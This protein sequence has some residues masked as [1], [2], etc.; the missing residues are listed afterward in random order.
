MKVLLIQQPEGLITAI[1]AI[2]SFNLVIFL[3]VLLMVLQALV[4][5]LRY[6]C[7]YSP[8]LSRFHQIEATCQYHRIYSNTGYFR[9][10][11]LLPALSG[12]QML[13]RKRS[14]F[15]FKSKV[16]YLLIWNFCL[17]SKFAVE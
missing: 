9:K 16:E 12:S 3:L 2:L 4:R 15:I 5:L 14:I 6:H 13:I 7:P 1:L 11:G 17:T 8:C 10:M